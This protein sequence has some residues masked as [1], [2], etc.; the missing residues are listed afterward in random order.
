MQNP[1]KPP[2]DCLKQCGAHGVC[3]QRKKTPEVSTKP[4]PKALRK[5]HRK[6]RGGLRKNNRERSRAAQSPASRK[7]SQYAKSRTLQNPAARNPGKSRNLIR[8][9]KRR[10]PASHLARNFRRSAQRPAPLKATPPSSTKAA[11]KTPRDRTPP[12]G[13]RRNAPREERV[14][15]K[16]RN[17]QR[18]RTILTGTHKR[19]RQTIPPNTPPRNLAMRPRAACEP[20]APPAQRTTHAM[21]KPLTKKR[22][23][24]T[25]KKCAPHSKNSATALCARGAKY[26]YKNAPFAPA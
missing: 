3:A 15:R 21:P 17:A 23:K 19:R 24:N 13:L 8:K 2:E 6:L 20:A 14:Q 22:K 10:R 7:I 25:R 5:F 16:F 18:V 12:A 11:R 4:S 9:S 26:E 1:A